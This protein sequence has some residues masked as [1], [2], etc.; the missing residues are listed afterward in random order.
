[1]KKMRRV[2]RLM[3]NEKALELLKKGEYGI[4][5]TLDSEG[6]PFGTPVN[7]VF[8]EGNIY[9][10]SAIEGTKLD[11]I[12]NNPKVCLTVVGETELDSKDFSTNYESVM[13]F[14]KASLVEGND[15]FK[16]LMEVVKKYSPDFIKEGEAYIKSSINQAFVIK[17]DV[18]TISGKHRVKK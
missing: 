13:A 14:G 9:F 18:E 6:Q 10:H 17:I 16:I 1:M 5:S 4:L 11:N 7:Y 2:D 3:T 8:C 12:E 15:K